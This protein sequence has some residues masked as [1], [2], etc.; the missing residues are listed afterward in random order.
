[1]LSLRYAAAA[2][3]FSSLAAEF[4]PF[5]HETMWM[6]KRVGSPAPSPDGNWVIVP[7]TEPDYDADKQVSD[8]WMV[9]AD[10]SAAPRRITYTKGGESGVVWSPDSRRI[11]FSAKREGDEKAQIYVMDIAGGGEAIRV[12]N[13][14]MGA[15]SP[16]WSPDGGRLLF[17]STVY[18]GAFAPEAVKKE[19]E[20][21]KKRKYQVRAYDGF[22]I[23]HWDD[24]LD[25]SDVHLFVQEARPGASATNLLAQSKLARQPGFGA[26]RGLSGGQLGAVWAPDG[27]SVVFTAT[28]NRHE[29]ARATVIRHVYRVAADGGEPED[30]TPGPDS[31]SA[32]KF[33]PDGGHL[34]ALFEPNTRFVYNLSRLARLSWPRG[35]PEI[36]TAGFDRDPASFQFSPDGRTVFLQVTE[37]AVTKIFRMPA[38]GGRPELVA[39]PPEGVYSGLASPERAPR[40]ML[41]A[42]WES[43]RRPAEIVRIDAASG[44]AEP[45]TAFNREDAARIEALPARHFTFTSSKGRQIHSLLI[46]PPGF[47]ESRKYP[48]VIFIH[49]GPHSASI[50]DF[51][52]RWNYLLMAQPG[53]VILAP[54]YTGSTS[55]GEKFAQAIQGD[56]LETPGEEINEAADEAVKRFPFL[57]GTRMAAGGASYGGHL[58]NWLQATTTRYRCL[59]SHA[60]LISLEGQW[61]T[62]DTIY[63]R[64]LMNGGPPWAGSPVWEKQSPFHYAAKFQTPVLLTI[65]ERDFRVPLNQTLAYWALLQRRQVP[66]RLLVFPR[67]NH[68]IQN[69]EDNRYFYQELM[70][71]LARHLGAD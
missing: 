3:A 14:A 32:A 65:G 68:W 4:A 8:L 37:E 6:M 15:F 40:P 25:D 71:W 51:H 36:L 19:A 62:S 58:A 49:G 48:L 70:T 26:S 46:L 66:S 67:A 7:V 9:P 56:P 2:L 31:F 17:Q 38:D 28:V 16:Q 33:S 41:F 30:V 27:K 23:R 55:F 47:E 18:P 54:N 52:Y 63:H 20:D 5:T 35:Q 45:L 53:Y 10:G 29:A 60:G 69:G 11:A 57:D 43:H 24:W 34:Y 39:G 12:T 21:R 44:K 64:E 50:D 1:M 13:L 22:P 42:S 59:F 61:A